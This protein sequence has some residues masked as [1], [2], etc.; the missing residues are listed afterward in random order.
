M[1][2]LT[3]LENGTIIGNINDDELAFLNTHRDGY[4][5]DSKIYYLNRT[6]LE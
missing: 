3:D 2:L 6:Y 5:Y 4:L 1:P